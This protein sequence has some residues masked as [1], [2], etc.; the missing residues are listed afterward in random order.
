[1][2]VART[3][4]AQGVVEGAGAADHRPHR[5]EDILVVSQPAEPLDRH[6][7]PHDGEKAVAEGDT[8]HVGLYTCR[9][10]QQRHRDFEEP[11]L[12]TACDGAATAREG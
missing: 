12:P 4:V 8:R 3:G 5:L 7:H 6:A 9:Q 11:P 1:L 10:N 2:G